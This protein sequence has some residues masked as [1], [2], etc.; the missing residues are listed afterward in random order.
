MGM[1]RVMNNEAGTLGAKSNSLLKH[2]SKCGF[3]PNGNG[4]TLKIL[5][6]ADGRVHLNFLENPSKCFMKNELT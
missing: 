3:Y 5:K 6:H 4:K 1:G 2:A